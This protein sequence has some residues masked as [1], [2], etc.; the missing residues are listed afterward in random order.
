MTL[1][2]SH[3]R[4]SAADAPHCV[5]G[6][7]DPEGFSLSTKVCQTVGD[8]PVLFITPVLFLSLAQSHTILG[9]CSS[10]DITPHF[11]GTFV[12]LPH[13]SISSHIANITFTPR[14]L[15]DC[16][17]SMLIHHQLPASPTS[18]KRKLQFR[19]CSSC[20]ER[21]TPQW[22]GGPFGNNT[23][24]NVCGLLYAKRQTKREKSH[25]RRRSTRRRRYR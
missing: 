10:R 6:H 13:L 14:G 7:Y 16:V 12:L 5:L 8:C 4:E 25:S 17:L 3:F 1:K 22:R 18:E 19:V 9:M 15:P 2:P 24:C 21:H 11:L 23:L 20:G